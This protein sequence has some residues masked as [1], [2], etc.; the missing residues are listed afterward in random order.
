VLADCI[1]AV[2]DR[3]EFTDPND[4]HA[5]ASVGALALIKWLNW[6]G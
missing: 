6:K 3:D 2:L 4:V 5:V 1:R